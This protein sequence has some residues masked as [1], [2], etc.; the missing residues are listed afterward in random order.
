LLRSFLCF[1]AAAACSGVKAGCMALKLK[2]SARA[3]GHTRW[4]GELLQVEIA[5]DRVI[6]ECLLYWL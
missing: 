2:V 1:A 5:T 4:R 3:V 6:T